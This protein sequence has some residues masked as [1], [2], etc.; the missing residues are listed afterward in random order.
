MNS[1]EELTLE[2]VTEKS[3]SR[4]AA[5]REPVWYSHLF[6]IPDRLTRFK[7]DWENYFRLREIGDLV[8]DKGEEWTDEEVIDQIREDAEEWMSVDKRGEWVRTPGIPQGDA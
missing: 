2:L 1:L 4:E 3:L 8:S 6:K 5:L 7:E